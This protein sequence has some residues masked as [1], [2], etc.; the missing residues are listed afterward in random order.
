[1]S[2]L[3]TKQST[4]SKSMVSL[5]DIPPT[6][7]YGIGL[8]NCN[9]DYWC[10]GALKHQQNRSDIKPKLPIYLL[11]LGFLFH[12][13]FAILLVSRLR[14]IGTGW[15]N[16]IHILFFPVRSTFRSLLLPTSPNLCICEVCHIYYKWSAV[17]IQQSGLAPS[18]L[19]RR[20][21][22]K[23][24]KVKGTIVCCTQQ[25]QVKHCISYPKFHAPD[26]VPNDE[27]CSAAGMVGRVSRVYPNKGPNPWED[28]SY[29]ASLHP[30]N[31]PETA[32]YS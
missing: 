13:L 16:S 12:V 15:F 24:N 3:P 26:V 25:A 11:D 2:L 19:I 28:L 17:G 23:G 9:C 27:I 22:G 8:V 21:A 10:Y 18:I 32:A 1:M 5:D 14:S 7:T 31:T 29:I 30:I 20:L 4:V 6:V